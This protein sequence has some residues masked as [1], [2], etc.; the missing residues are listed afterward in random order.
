VEE[1]MLGD[2]RHIHQK[3]GI[4]CSSVDGAQT[5]DGNPPFEVH[6]LGIYFVAFQ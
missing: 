6:V 2:D 4:F 5:A 3:S 1:D